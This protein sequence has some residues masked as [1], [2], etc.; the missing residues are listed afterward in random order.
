M[1]LEL[2]LAALDVLWAD[3]RLGRVP[4]PLE[5]RSHGDTL[6]D[7]ARI[8]AAVY[9]DL[10]RRGLARDE[11]PADTLVEDLRLLADP[12][13]IVDLV[14]LLDMDDAEPMKALAA[15]RGR[16]G[17]LVV[18]GKLTLR[19]I[20]MRDIY[21]TGALVDL[22]PATRAGAGN[23][24]TSPAGALRAGPG[25][26]RG[27]QQGGVLRKVAPAVADAT[28]RAIAA[29]MEQSVR[30]AGQLGVTRIDDAGRRHRLPGIA[31]FDTDDGRYATTTARGR[32]GEDWVT[33]WPADNARLTHRL[34][35]LAATEI[36]S[37][38]G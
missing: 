36:V 38:R 32:D 7:R 20:R 35:E 37:G 27:E 3:L 5:I 10:G 26:Q 31:W 4:F 14:A 34:A 24:I 33:L 25:R 12:T 6:D 17:I 29:V 11:R 15:T 16:H 13:K 18:Q 8:R 2:S 1:S 22:L 19:L 23:S 21:T 28:L 30:R 9:A